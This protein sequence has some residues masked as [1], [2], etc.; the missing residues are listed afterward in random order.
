MSSPLGQ[1]SLLSKEVRAVWLSYQSPTLVHT[2]PLS[3]ALPDR[4]PDANGATV[5]SGSTSIPIDQI[6]HRFESLE[7]TRNA[8]QRTEEVLRA[9]DDRRSVF[10]TIYVEMTKAVIQEIETEAFH[11]PAWARKYLIEFAN[12]YREALL[13]FEQGNMQDIPQPWQ[14]AFSA[15]MSGHTLVIQDLLLG[16]NAHINYD[17]AYT[18]TEID[19]DPNRS[20]KL[21][22][23][24]QI[25]R[26]LASLID[27]AQSI[28]SERYSTA[29]LA[30]VDVSR[31]ALR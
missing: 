9:A 3:D 4:E 28:I 13:N 29:G 30:E 25:N 24:N 7:Q 18:L 27:T 16:V 6:T 19:I 10:L 31:G 14:L 21:R 5:A 23:H 17:L 22:D 1:L 2:L 8:L 26:I 11:D 15:S 12:W 20:K